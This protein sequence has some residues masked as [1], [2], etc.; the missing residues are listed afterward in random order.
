[1]SHTDF[2]QGA[3]RDVIGHMDP[4]LRADVM[5]GLEND[6]KARMLLHFIDPSSGFPIET[7]ADSAM[8]VAQKVFF[9]DFSRR[10]TR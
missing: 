3:D 8:G 2:P 10:R 7:D 9:R 1:M 5:Q 6:D 4:G